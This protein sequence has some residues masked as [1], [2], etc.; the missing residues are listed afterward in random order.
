VH[1][2]PISGDFRELDLIF[3]GER[4]GAW[5]RNSHF[6]AVA[7]LAGAFVIGKERS[8]CRSLTFLDEI[9]AT[10]GQNYGSGVSLT[11]QQFHRL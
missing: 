10:R 11:N 3:K 9:M 5:S 4:A 8:S 1:W 2:I 7:S 6:R